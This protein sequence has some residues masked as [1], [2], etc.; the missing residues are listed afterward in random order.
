M[1]LELDCGNSLIKWR[2]VTIAGERLLSGAVSEPE[3]VLEAVA[4]QPI[5]YC[6]LVSV[7]SDEETEALRSTLAQALAV[8][9]QVAR[10]LETLG[11]VV[12]GYEMPERLGV[13]RWLAIVGAYQC[14]Q[15]A[16]LVLDLGTAVTADFVDASGRHLGGFI[17]PGIELMRS[18]LQQHTRRIRYQ[19]PQTLNEGCHLPGRNTVE[20]VERGCVW[21]LQGFVQTQYR[22]AVEL[23]GEDFQVFFTGGDAALVVEHFTDAQWVDDLVFK[24]LE[25]ACPVE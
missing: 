6:R 2:V 23:L 25:I 21:M 10:A 7:R 9:V 15:Q 1:I 14:A 24:G 16:C 17:G 11:V 12:N 18:Q 19:A 8:D 22:M 5:R 4:S 3:L 13:D 20:A